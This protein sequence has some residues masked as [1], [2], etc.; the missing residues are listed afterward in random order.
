MISLHAEHVGHH[1]ILPHGTIKQPPNLNNNMTIVTTAKKLISL[2]TYV[3]LGPQV[4]DDTKSKGRTVSTASVLHFVQGK[5]L[6]FSVS[7][8]ASCCCVQRPVLYDAEDHGEV[9]L[10]RHLNPAVLIRVVASE[11]VCQPLGK[12]QAFR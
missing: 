5:N 10:V 3:Q 9:L 2:S 12:T 11:Y 1:C 4:I 7:F 6:A 8:P